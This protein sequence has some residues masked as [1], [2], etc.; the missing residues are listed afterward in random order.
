MS[1]GRNV[2]NLNRRTEVRK[3][4]AVTLGVLVALLC[5]GAVAS[6]GIINPVK[7]SASVSPSHQIKNPPYTFT[8]SGK[9]T[10][11][12]YICPPGTP[13]PIPGQTNTCAAITAK[14]ACSGKISLSVTLGKDAILADANKTIKKT[15]GKVSGKC[16][17]SIKTKFPKSDFTAKA[18]YAPHTAGEYVH[19]SFHVKFG[20][21]KVLNG[22]SARTQNV[23]AKLINP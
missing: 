20:G 16:T 2:A 13:K 22:K 17:Y 15:S 4:A 6:A 9:I 23:V 14:E 12:S 11:P 21:N 1:Q 8:T 3:P 7:V 10:F 19:V 5:F 18:P